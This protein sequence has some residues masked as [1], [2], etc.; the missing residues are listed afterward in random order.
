MPDS[1]GKLTQI[2]SA[3]SPGESASASLRDP[4]RHI[5]HGLNGALNSLS[6]NIELL[7][8]V[9]ET[10]DDKERRARCLAS[11]RR[12][13]REIQQ[14]VERELLPLAREDRSRS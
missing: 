12:A 5:V 3:R 4:V 11:L 1:D 9:A 13:T 8:K 14:I 2:E 6:L 10:G 7:E